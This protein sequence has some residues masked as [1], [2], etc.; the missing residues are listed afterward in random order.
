MVDVGRV[1]VELLTSR[2]CNAELQS[3]EAFCKRSPEGTDE[4]SGRLISVAKELECR[5]SKGQRSRL[6]VLLSYDLKKHVFEDE[7]EITSP[8]Y[9]KP[10][11]PELLAT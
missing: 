6:L 8:H 9:K 1:G 11:P 4:E 2:P 7:A 3:V 10:S 5:L